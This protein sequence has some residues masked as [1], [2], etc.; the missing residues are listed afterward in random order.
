MRQYHARVQRAIHMSQILTSR[1]TF[2]TTSRSTT[3]IIHLALLVAHLYVSAN[4]LLA[5]SF[6]SISGRVVS[7][8]AYSCHCCFSLDCYFF[9]FFIFSFFFFFFFFFF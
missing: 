5:L 1:P 2:E 7:F 8:S 9:S 6:I 4:C 3:Q